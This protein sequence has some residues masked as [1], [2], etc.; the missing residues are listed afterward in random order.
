MKVIS[1]ILGTLAVLLL[2][3]GAHT[4]IAQATLR[5]GDAVE[6]R[7]AGVPA[8]EM[9]QFSAPYT[10]DDAGAINLP[11][12][13]L[14]KVTGLAYNQAQALIEN[15][16]KEGKIYTHPSITITP[17]ARFIN[18][19]GEVKSPGRIPYTP[20]AK[21]LAVI[22]AAGGFTD[23][24]DKRKVHLTRDNKIQII[25]AKDI[26]KHPEKDIPI[27]PGDQIE[28]MKGWL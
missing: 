6:V 9:G 7:L 17:G 26:A 8:E 19:G 12:I 1:K 13:G 23:F 25:D 11:Y 5:V 3:G 20:D 28:V 15:K 24:A 22:N 16:L 4:A 27:F 10:V 2:T 21:L 18:I 14:I